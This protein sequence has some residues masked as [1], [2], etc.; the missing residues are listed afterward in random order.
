M[1]NGWM[2]PEEVFYW[3]EK[4]IEHDSKILEFGSGQGTVRLNKNFQVTSVEHNEEFLNLGNNEYILARI[5]PNKVSQE[6]S[7]T[8]WYDINVLNDLPNKVKVI[9]ID[10]PPGDIGRMGILQVLHELPISNWMIVDDTDRLDEKILCEKI[11]KELNPMEIHTITSESYRANGNYR[12]A[13]L[14]RLR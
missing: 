3:L 8:G 1:S 2:L 4:N 5:T 9:I 6:H 11:I 14:L 7:Q 10:G 13:T 12:E